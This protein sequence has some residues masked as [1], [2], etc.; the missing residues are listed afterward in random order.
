M[1]DTNLRERTR[2]GLLKSEQLHALARELYYGKR[3][4]IHKQDWIEQR[5]SSSCMTLILACI[6]YWQ[7]KEIHR[8][9]LEN[10]SEFQNDW[11]LVEHIS[12]IA[13][14]N[15]ILYGDYVL[16]KKLIKL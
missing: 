11:P 9:L 7:A 10:P 12:P 8:V 1:S 13:W 5:N 15:V 16:D 3:G 14:E 6:I 2:K 4:R